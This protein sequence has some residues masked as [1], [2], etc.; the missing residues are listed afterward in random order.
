MYSNFHTHSTFCDGKNTPEEMVRAA[1]AAGM[2]VLGFSEHSYL[3]FDSSYCLNPETEPKYREEILRLKEKYRGQIRLMLGLEQ[4]C[5]SKPAYPEYEYLIGSVHYVPADGRYCPVDATPEILMRDVREHFSGDVYAY[6]RAYYE[7]EAKVLETT[8]AEIVGHFDLLTKFN[9]KK[10]LFDENDPRYRRAALDAL[11][12][13]LE[14]DPVF[15]INTGAIS[16]GW[17]RTPYPSP[18]L[19]RRIAEKRGRVTVSADAHS[20]DGIACGFADAVHLLEASGI[21]RVFVLG[22]NGWEAIPTG[23]FLL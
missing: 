5:F 12:A 2:K 7:L 23:R 8:R 16:R 13:L 17:R 15:E 10:P 20:A 21:S 4:D 3:P 19:L 11:D 1:I 6:V 9:E 14:K 22:E 18:L